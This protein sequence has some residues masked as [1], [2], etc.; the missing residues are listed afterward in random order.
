MT[1]GLI[2]VCKLSGGVQTVEKAFCNYAPGLT[3]LG[4]PGRSAIAI[5]VAVLGVAG[6][7]STA[8]ALLLVAASLG[9]GAV[10]ASDQ[11][12]ALSILSTIRNGGG[13]SLWW[14]GR[15]RLCSIGV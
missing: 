7:C 14:E 8:G 2:A 12:G 10:P 11:E 6:T 15:D 5:N 3:F 13:A 1:E 9:L 4:V